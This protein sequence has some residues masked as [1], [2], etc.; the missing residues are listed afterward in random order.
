MNSSMNRSQLVD[1][2][3]AHQHLS[4]IDAQKIVNTV[5]STITEGLSNGQ[6]VEIRGFG[7]FAPRIQKAKKAR[8]PKTGESIN[9]KSSIKVQY[10]PGKELKEQVN[11]EEK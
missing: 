7:S 6:R 3:A 1:N 8:N 4:N 2:F 9:A 5:L 10:R 11:K